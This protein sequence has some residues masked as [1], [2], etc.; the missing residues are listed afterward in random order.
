MPRLDYFKDRMYWKYGF[1]LTAHEITIKFLADAKGDASKWFNKL[2]KQ[3]TVVILHISRDFTMGDIIGRGH[4]SKLQLAI[5][6]ETSK[7][8]AIKSIVKQKLFEN[9][10]SLVYMFY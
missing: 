6:N 9:D 4:Y 1:S 5:S 10:Y 7:K 8:Y 3:A 2:K